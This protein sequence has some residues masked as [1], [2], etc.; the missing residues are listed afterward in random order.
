V[1]TTFKAH[2]GAILG[3]RVVAVD[4]VG[5]VGQS[6]KSLDEEVGSAL[7]RVIRVVPAKCADRRAMG[8]E[9]EVKDEAN[10]LVFEIPR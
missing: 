2:D 7:P 3:N 10:S 5:D 4:A 1:L 6:P 8:L 9:A